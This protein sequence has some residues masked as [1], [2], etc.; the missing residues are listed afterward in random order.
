MLNVASQI[1][2]GFA[3]PREPLGRPEWNSKQ[4]LVR[5]LEPGDVWAC[6]SLL[7]LLAAGHQDSA[8]ITRGVAARWSYP[9]PKGVPGAAATRVSAVCC[10][11]PS[12]PAS[13]LQLKKLWNL[14][15]LPT[16]N[17]RGS[18]SVSI[19]LITPEGSPV[20][21]DHHP[22]HLIN[23]WCTCLLY[24]PD[25]WRQRHYSKWCNTERQSWS[26]SD[27][28]VYLGLAKIFVRSD[29]KVSQNNFNGALS[30]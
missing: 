7:P 8:S 11:S 15:R 23:I 20:R 25:D 13:S 19:I 18:A 16:S 28:P 2:H 6:T 3:V 21:A 10:A 17:S 9:N 29:E 5:P 12:C 24:Q 1:T 27:C 4:G 30:I 26:P 14:L 22:G